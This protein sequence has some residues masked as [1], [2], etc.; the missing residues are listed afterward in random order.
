MRVETFAGLRDGDEEGLLLAACLSD[1]G[2]RTFATLADPP[3]REA[4]DREE[5]CRREGRVSEGAL[6][7]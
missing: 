1:D 4:L 3:P 5:L 6:R 7:L 2:V